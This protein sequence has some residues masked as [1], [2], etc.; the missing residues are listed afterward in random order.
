MI[1]SIRNKKQKHIA[2][3]APAF[4]SQFGDKITPAQVFEGIKMLGFDDVVEVGLGAD[5]ATINEAKFLH[6]VPNELPC[7]NKLLSCL[8][9]YG[10][11]N[12]PG[13]SATSI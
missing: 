4:V 8:G 7:S 6:V 1:K 9:I 13:S 2:I 12:V 10:K 3:V 5:I 11:Q